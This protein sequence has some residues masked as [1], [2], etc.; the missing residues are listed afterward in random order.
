MGPYRANRSSRPVE[1]ECS[2]L[3]GNI[4]LRIISIVTF[5]LMYSKS[6]GFSGIGNRK[7]SRSLFAALAS[8]DP[9]KPFLIKSTPYS[10]RKVSYVSS[11]FWALASSGSL[12]P[13]MRF[14][15]TTGLSNLI[16]SS[17]STFAGI[18]SLEFVK[19]STILSAVMRC[20]WMSA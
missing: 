10:P 8:S 14:H 16:S 4:K 2:K 11:N 17:P 6:G 18:V 9:W 3:G 5:V 12:L 20:S 19:S 13:I 15:L 7:I 1:F